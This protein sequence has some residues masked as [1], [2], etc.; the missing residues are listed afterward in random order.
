MERRNSPRFHVRLPVV[1]SANS[2]Q[3][4]GRVINISMS[5]CALESEV[6]VTTVMTLRLLFS[7]PSHDTPLEVQLAPVRWSQGGRFGLEFI[8]MPAEAKVRLRQFLSNL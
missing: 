4:Y 6:H 7:L 3:S 5:G 8:M 2:S 1:F